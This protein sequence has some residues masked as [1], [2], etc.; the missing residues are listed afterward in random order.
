M[1]T[2]VVGASGATG[3]QLVEQLLQ[4]GQQVKIIVRP[5][6]KI[7]SEWDNNEAAT[8][9]RAN[10]SE[11]TTDEIAVC[12]KDCQAI[13]CCLGHNPTVKGLFGKPRKLVTNAVKLLCSVVERNSPES[14]VKF[15]LMSSV[16]VRYKDLGENASLGQKVIMSIIRLLAPP[17]RDNE[18]AADYLRFNIGQNNTKIQWAAVRPDSLINEDNVT[19]YKLYASPTKSLFKPGKTSRINVGHFMARLIAENDLWEE[20]KGRMPAIYNKENDL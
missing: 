3:K 11:M 18:K 20:W 13:A 10:I 2:L 7:F 17:H 14:T 8:I 9:I 12:T 5:T 4:M 16:A 15:V 1:T 6:A 19:E